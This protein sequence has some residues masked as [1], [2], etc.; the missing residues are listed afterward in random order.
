[1]ILGELISRFVKFNLGLTEATAVDPSTPEEILRYVSERFS[2]SES[3]IVSLVEDFISKDDFRSSH[4]Q[5]VTDIATTV[6]HLQ[7]NVV[8]ANELAWDKFEGT[9]GFL[10]MLRDRDALYVYRLSNERLIKDALVSAYRVA[11]Q[12]WVDKLGVCDNPNLIAFGQERLRRLSYEICRLEE[13]LTKT[14]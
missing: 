6:A 12:V 4:D 8:N 7:G 3:L 14:M 13:G 10:D 9:I 1:M 11:Q 2:T 5:F